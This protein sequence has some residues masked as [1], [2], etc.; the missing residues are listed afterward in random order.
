MYHYLECL[1]TSCS[2]FRQWWFHNSGWTAVQLVLGNWRWRKLTI[3]CDEDMGLLMEMGHQGHNIYF[4]CFYFD[5]SCLNQVIQGWIPNTIYT[6]GQTLYMCE[7]QIATQVS[8]MELYAGISE[9]EHP[10]NHLLTIGT[11]DHHGRQVKEFQLFHLLT[12]VSFNSHCHAVWSDWRTWHLFSRVGYSTSSCRFCR[13]QAVL[14]CGT[15]CNHEGW[16]VVL[17]Q[18]YGSISQITTEKYFHTSINRGS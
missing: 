15:C 16:P 14:S 17:E 9:R 5:V 18:S 11:E 1:S 7:Q 13:E 12:G 6:F 4:S 3:R 2:E 8:N 10:S